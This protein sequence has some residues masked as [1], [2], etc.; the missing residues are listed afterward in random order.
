M[1]NDIKII[2]RKVDFI[3]I[4]SPAM[5]FVPWPV[6]EASAIFLTGEKLFDVKNSVIATI[7]MVINIPIRLAK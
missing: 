7:P 4:A 5:I 2:G 6:F 3:E 1:A